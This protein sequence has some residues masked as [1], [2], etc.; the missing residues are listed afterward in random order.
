MSYAQIT[1]SLFIP[2]LHP[3]VY[4]DLWFFLVDIE[5]SGWNFVGKSILSIFVFLPFVGRSS[6][7]K[8]LACYTACR[9]RLKWMF[10]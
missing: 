10:S 6:N 7:P 2:S 1:Q 4:D 5:R 3:L 8:H 9:I